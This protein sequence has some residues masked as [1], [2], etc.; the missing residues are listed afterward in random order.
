MKTFYSFK[1]MFQTYNSGVKSR[2]VVI[3][4]R[5]QTNCWRT[6]GRTSQQLQAEFARSATDGQSSARIDCG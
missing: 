4:L 3:V 5:T 2:P 6:K 1:S